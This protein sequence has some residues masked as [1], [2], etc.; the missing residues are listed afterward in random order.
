MDSC[1]CTT[2]HHISYNMSTVKGDYYHYFS[3][4]QQLGCDQ[5]S[6]CGICG[7]LLEQGNPTSALYFSPRADKGDGVTER[8]KDRW[9][10]I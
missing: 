3:D 2:I 10:L 6:G 8:D 9:V 7:S 4:I 1:T 5:R